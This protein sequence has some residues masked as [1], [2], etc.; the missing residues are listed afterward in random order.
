VRASFLACKYALPFLR[1]SENASIVN[2]GLAD[3]LTAQPSRLLDATVHGAMI[4]MTRSL[5]VDCGPHGIRVN[6]ICAGHVDT[7]DK[8]K[9]LASSSDP[10][11]ALERILAVHPLGR[12]GQ[13]VEIAQAVLFLLSEAASFVTGAQL[14]VDG[15]R[16][17]VAQ[18]I[19]DI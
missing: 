4:S 15:G 17:I 3:A 18:D 16:S 9:T 6:S 1:R 2:V 10:E 14:T 11:S 12:I 7:E 8:Q 13:P 19:H 5:A